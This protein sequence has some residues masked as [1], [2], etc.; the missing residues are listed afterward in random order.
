MCSRI[1]PDVYLGFFG[2]KPA[3]SWVIQTLVVLFKEKKMQLP[4]VLP[5]GRLWITSP[6]PCHRGAGRFL[7]LR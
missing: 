4:T 3:F 1:V 5:A 7:F 6:L 2:E